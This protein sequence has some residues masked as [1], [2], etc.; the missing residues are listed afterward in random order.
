MRNWPT[1]FACGVSPIS[2]AQS[3]IEANKH[4]GWMTYKTRDYQKSSYLHS[5]SNKHALSQTYFVSAFT[6]ST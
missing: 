3:G 1:C 4:L 5:D 2:I 6:C